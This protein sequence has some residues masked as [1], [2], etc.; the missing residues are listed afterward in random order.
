MGT[1]LYWS[2]AVPVIIRERGRQRQ[3][4]T[5]MMRHDKGCG[6]H[7]L[8]SLTH[9]MKTVN[10]N[11]RVAPLVLSA[12]LAQVIN[13]RWVGLVL[14]R[15]LLRDKGNPAIIFIEQGI[16][17]SSLSGKEKAEIICKGVSL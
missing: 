15:L 14:T 17:I 1:W 10:K 5:M 3:E 16:L 7:A 2:L 8:L 9:I 12:S 13:P 11:T 6:V 4:E